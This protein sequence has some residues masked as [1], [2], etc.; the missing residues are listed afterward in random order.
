MKAWLIFSLLRFGDTSYLK[1]FYPNATRDELYKILYQSFVMKKFSVAEYWKDP[2]HLDMYLQVTWNLWGGGGEL[3]LTRFYLS[4]FEV[5]DY[6]V[7]LN[8]ENGTKY[9]NPT[10]TANFE[11]LSQLVLIGGPDDG[12]ITPWQSSQ[13]GFYDQNLNVVPMQQQVFP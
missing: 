11:R 1:Y 2:F 10:F 6:L 3:S 9:V 4:Y 8:N 5:N 7:A 12:V 13:F